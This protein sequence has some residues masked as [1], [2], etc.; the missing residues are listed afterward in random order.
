MET[1]TFGSASGITFAFYLF[2]LIGLLIGFAVYWLLAH[3]EARKERF[4]SWPAASRPV[5]AVIGAGV[6]LLVILGVYFTSLAGFHRLELR[7]D[8]LRVVYI[9][10][11]RTE[12]FR[13]GQIAEVRRTSG[14]RGMWRLDLYTPAGRRVESAQGDY[15]TVRQAWARVE[16]YLE[17]PSGSGPRSV[18]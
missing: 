16:A 18:Q 3:P 8:D 10:P 11:Q 14:Y 9:L 17:P 1:F 6:A 2:L 12:G 4:R 5:A 7:G 15:A 13:R